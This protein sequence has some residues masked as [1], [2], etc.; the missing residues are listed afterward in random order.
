[1]K[2]SEKIL[3][4][5]AKKM[6]ADAKKMRGAADR[7][8]LNADKLSSK[9]ADKNKSP[10]KDLIDLTQHD[11]IIIPQVIPVEP[12]I[13]QPKLVPPY[14][15][16]YYDNNLDPVEPSTDDLTKPKR[17]RTKKLKPKPI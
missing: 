6:Q 8:Q 5:K 15:V 9:V 10:P 3:A 11:I 1:M 4:F 16:G 14:T 12:V 13:I 7:M 2:T 17:I